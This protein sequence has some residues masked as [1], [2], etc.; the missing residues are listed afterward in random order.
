VTNYV[1]T[2]DFMD[3]L[4]DKGVVPQTEVK[5]NRYVS[6]FKGL[7]SKLSSTVELPLEH[8]DFMDLMHDKGFVPVPCN[9][10]DMGLDTQV[11]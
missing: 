6:L 1:S 2:Y 7:V 11:A 9:D 5:T 8:H 3:L 4:N 10:N